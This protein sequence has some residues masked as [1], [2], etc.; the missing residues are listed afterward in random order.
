MQLPL[1]KGLK[2]YSAKYTKDTISCMAKD[3]MIFSAKK[4]FCILI[5]FLKT[6]KL[7]CKANKLQ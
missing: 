2:L 3:L 6:G 4:D 5:A 1:L 7:Y